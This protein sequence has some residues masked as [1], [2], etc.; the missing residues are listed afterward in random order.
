M[1]VPQLV[2]HR[3]WPRHYPENTLIG[4]DAAIAA[5]ARFVEVDVQITRDRIPVLFHDRDLRRVCGVDGRVHE[6]RYDELWA[7]RA[8]EPKKFGD[9]FDEVHIPRLAEL[10]HLLRRSPDVTAF[11]ELKRQSLDQFGTRTMLDLVRRALKPAAAQCVLI[12]YSLE[13]LLAAHRERWPRL[14]V[15]VDKWDER[16]QE[17]VG[18]IRPQYLFC[19]VDGLPRAGRLHMDGTKLAVFE[20]TDARVALALAERGV[21]FVETF[22]IGEMIRDLQRLATPAR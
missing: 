22:E 17:I 8:A 4:I 18:A 6:Y 19:D 14:G 10:G 16:N 20:V 9:R 7:F 15:V 5:G 13:A 11:I 12:S 2:A 1:I 3:G 21:E